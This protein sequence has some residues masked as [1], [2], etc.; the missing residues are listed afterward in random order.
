[1]TTTASATTSTWEVQV[2]EL[3]ACFPPSATTILFCFQALAQDPEADFETV[4][5]QASHHGLRITNASMNGAKRLLANAEGS[6]AKAPKA[7]RGDEPAA[8][9]QARR[10]RPTQGAVDEALIRGLAGK[11]QAHAAAEADSLRDAMRRAIH[12]LTD[13]VR[14]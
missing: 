11:L 8:P 7:D 3:K 14:S 6:P 9:T 5:E 1:M 10:P 13:A 4:K 2:K 12:I